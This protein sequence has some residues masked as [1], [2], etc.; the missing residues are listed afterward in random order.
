MKYIMKKFLTVIMTVLTLSLVMSSC[1][2]DKMFVGVPSVSAIAS[3]P[4]TATQDDAVTISAVLYDLSGIKSATLN[5]T[6]NGGAAQSV[7]M[8][9]S[10]TTYTAVIPKQAD[11][12]VVK[13]TITAVSNNDK[14]FTSA[15][16]SYTVGEGLGSLSD[17][18]INEVNSDGKY[19]EIYNTSDKAVVIS[20]IKFAKN[21][22]DAYF[23]DGTAAT[24]QVAEGTKLGAKSY[25]I[26]GCK[27]T[28]LSAD[29]AA[30]GAM[31][32]GTSTTGLSGKKSLLVI[33][34][35]KDGKTVDS[36][37]NSANT[38]PAISD[39]WDGAVEY[40]FTVAAR[41]PDGTGD[42]Y[43]VTEAT[44]G[45]TNGTTPSANKFTHKLN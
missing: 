39:T 24:I 7:D 25:A 45:K 5:Y 22:S 44:L 31:Y 10:G 36:F 1:V 27:G 9:L 42:F 34:Q 29:A 2:K 28:D 32:L 20:G 21:A 40:V 30:A 41:I 18:K 17:I 3:T 4:T 12:A 14:S 15:E 35:D 11:K 38:T 16:Q 6:V 33:L 23:V 13:Y 26:M 8:T 37:V 43:S 19:I